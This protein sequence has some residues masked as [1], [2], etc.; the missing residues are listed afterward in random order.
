MGCILSFFKFNN[1]KSYKITEKGGE[2]KSTNHGRKS[3]KKQQHQQQQPKYQQ[4]LQ[5]SG[6]QLEKSSGKNVPPL[7]SQSFVYKTVLEATVSDAT[8]NEEE[9]RINAAEAPGPFEIETDLLSPEIEEAVIK[10]Q[11]N[12]RGY[13][14]RKLYRGVTPDRSVE[15]S[16]QP[17]NVVGQSQEPIESSHN[18][19]SSSGILAPP[20]SFS[21]TPKEFPLD[22]DDNKT[23]ASQGKQIAD[24]LI[25]LEKQVSQ[26]EAINK[27]L[28]STS[29]VFKT[30]DEVISKKEKRENFNHDIGKVD[31]KQS[32]VD[33][34]GEKL[35]T[36][37]ENND[38]VQQVNN[39][40]ERQLEIPSIETSECTGPEEAAI[41]IQAA[42]RGYQVR[43]TISRE[44]SPSHTR[45]EDEDVVHLREKDAN[46][47]QDPE[48]ES[49]L[50]L[51]QLEE[52]LSQEL[53]RSSINIG[54]ETSLS[55]YS[56]DFDLNSSLQSNISLAAL[57]SSSTTKTT[58]EDENSD[59]KLPLLTS[60]NLAKT[61]DENIT[62][63]KINDETPTIP[64]AIESENVNKQ[65]VDVSSV[66]PLT[67]S[68]N[69]QAPTADDSVNQTECFD[70]SSKVEDT[71]EVIKSE[72]VLF[73]PT[74]EKVNAID[75][76]DLIDGMVKIDNQEIDPV[77]IV[78]L[79][80]TL[81]A[82]DVSKSNDK[83]IDEP[84]SIKKESPKK[85]TTIDSELE[86]HQSIEINRVGS[87][88]INETKSID[89]PEAEIEELEVE[90]LFS[91]LVSPL[92]E[93]TIQSNQQTSTNDSVN[94]SQKDEQITPPICDVTLSPSLAEI[95][96]SDNQSDLN[97]DGNTP[98]SLITETS[99]ESKETVNKLTKED[100]FG[101]DILV[102]DDEKN[103][104]LYDPFEDNLTCNP[105]TIQSSANNHEQL[106]ASATFAE[107]N[108]IKSVVDD[109]N[110]D[111]ELLLYEM[112]SG[113]TIKDVDLSDMNEN[114]NEIKDD[115]LVNLDESDD[116][117]DED[118]QK[119]PVEQSVNCVSKNNSIVQI[120]DE[121]QMIEKETKDL[122]NSAKQSKDESINDSTT[123]EQNIDSESLPDGHVGDLI[124]TEMVSTPEQSEA[125]ATIN[126]P[127]ENVCK[128]VIPDLF[129]S[130]PEKQLNIELA[131]SPSVGV[132]QQSMI[133]HDKSSIQEDVD[134]SSVS[135]NPFL[136]Q[137]DFDSDL[138]LGKIIPSD[139]KPI[140]LVGDENES[141][142]LTTQQSSQESTTTIKQLELTTSEVAI[143]KDEE[144]LKSIVPKESSEKLKQLE[145]LVAPPIESPNTI[146]ITETTAD[147]TSAI[148]ED[149]QSKADESPIKHDD[150]DKSPENQSKSPVQENLNETIIVV[151]SEVSNE[152]L[153]PTESATTSNNQPTVNIE[154]NVES[155]ITTINEPPVND[156]EE[157]DTSPENGNL[158]LRLQDRDTR[159][160]SPNP[161]NRKKRRHKKKS[162]PAN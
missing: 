77:V 32:S 28:E 4:S 3:S 10:I 156:D 88:S 100:S 125:V 9:A 147:L 51:D 82:S 23:A 55:S 81:D 73:V 64:D 104:T 118:S 158:L 33:C 5:Q 45:G 92:I 95:V 103:D 143:I 58:H 161:F 14:T 110:K 106:T 160:R 11:A 113:S 21:D 19:Q 72:P 60:S 122:S 50:V 153:A 127:S 62:T 49:I 112:N 54:D 136:N 31:Y 152:Q 111:K 102:L 154:T 121:N 155:N 6:P 41:K 66:D 120:Q 68:I 65:I 131:F 123:T 105:P 138:D 116:E 30:V 85:L 67:V 135:T 109:L 132:I 40:S 148:T 101:S 47:T 137:S 7:S 43:K 27:P 133:N 119:R 38:H 63:A 134:S 25:E 24:K 20:P 29:T 71:L 35:K 80:G 124:K 86:L 42:F 91:E 89:E 74:D 75:E 128:K 48:R 12:V 144:Q 36:Q 129:D 107:D 52:C 70:S 61:N 108:L 115:I 90:P 150:E 142:S 56:T 93:S 8:V 57:A 97:A 79:D 126:E 37:Y 16:Q 141:T 140:N 34:V 13:L 83:Q 76:T 2:D 145:I 17:S 53:M 157:V 87:S 149:N 130:Q 162:G 26:Q 159:S 18:E 78:E 22:H 146:Q 117:D 151:Q 39:S 46:S 1:N 114:I 99:E 84:K 139:Q 98:I 44:T 69:N 96:T 94:S 59:S 15:T